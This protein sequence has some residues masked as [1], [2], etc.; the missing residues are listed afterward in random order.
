MSNRQIFIL[1]FLL[2]IGMIGYASV[3]TVT[4]R[5][6]AVK[7]RLGQKMNMRIKINANGCVYLRIQTSLCPSRHCV[8]II[9]LTFSD[10]Q[11]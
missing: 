1:V 9:L 4:E 8:F 7:F 10:T 11:S 5:E 6:L 2:V 3:F